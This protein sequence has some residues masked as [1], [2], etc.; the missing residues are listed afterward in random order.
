MTLINYLTRNGACE[1]DDLS[2]FVAQT[3]NLALDLRWIG[4]LFERFLY[5]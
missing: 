5:H 4:M 3:I 2:F 1:C